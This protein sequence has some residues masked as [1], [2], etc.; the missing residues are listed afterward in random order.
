MFR[1]TLVIT[2]ALAALA[3]P[4]VCC[5]ASASVDV[6]QKRME[7]SSERHHSGCCSHHHRHSSSTKRPISDSSKRAPCR[8]PEHGHQPV[9]TVDTSS[10]DVSSL[11]QLAS[12]LAQSVPVL[13]SLGGEIS[14][15]GWKSFGDS[16]LAIAF[17]HLSARD[18]LSALQTLRC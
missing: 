15:S 12:A 8:C 6:R 3:N 10:A 14:L 11:I 17:P 2:L 7:T 16:G 9:A 18:I 13:S 5:C 4:L 1:L